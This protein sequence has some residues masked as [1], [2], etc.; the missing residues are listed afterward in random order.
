VIEGLV[1]A[2]DLEKKI[3]DSTSLGGKCGRLQNVILAF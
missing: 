1:S 2:E 3:L